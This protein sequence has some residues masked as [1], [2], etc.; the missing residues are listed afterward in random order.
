MN[1]LEHTM[2]CSSTSCPSAAHSPLHLPFAGS[3]NSAVL[4]YGFSA[5]SLQEPR[6]TN[7]STT[8][9]FV[10]N[11]MILILDGEQNGCLQKNLK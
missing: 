3:I 7:I 1:L 4:T 5:F 6:L 11:T 9:I 2:Y 8:S 10:Q